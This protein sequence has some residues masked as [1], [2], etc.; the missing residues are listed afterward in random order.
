MIALLL[1]LAQAAPALPVRV[2]LGDVPLPEATNVERVLVMRVNFA[3]GQEMPRHVHSAPVVC[4]V[5]SGSFS[6]QIG[7]APAQTLQAGEVTLEPANVTIGYFRNLSGT[8]P[9]SLVCTFLAGPGDHELSRMLP[10][11]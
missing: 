3:P 1:A 11:P 7:T 6:A 4:L 10:N 9:A 5:E 2:P 8:T